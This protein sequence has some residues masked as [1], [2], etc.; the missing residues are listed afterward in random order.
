MQ[1]LML[2]WQL[3]TTKTTASDRF[4]RALYTLVAH[5]ALPLSSRAPMFLALLYKVRGRAFGHTRMIWVPV[6]AAAWR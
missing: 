6:S 1:A 2:V 3:M 5:D 4:Y